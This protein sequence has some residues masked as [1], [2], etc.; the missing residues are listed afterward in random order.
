MIL[1]PYPRPAG[2]QAGF[3]ILEALIAAVLLVILSV[4]TVQGMI[5]H[6]RS[7]KA[8][9]TQSQFAEQ[10]RRLVDLISINALD[11]TSLEVENG[12][13]GNGSVLTIQKPSSANPAVLITN[14]FEYVDT[15]NN[16]N[17]IANNMILH[18][19]ADAPGQTG[20]VIARLVSRLP[21]NTPVFQVVPGTDRPLVHTRLRIG[22]RFA[23]AASPNTANYNA[24]N[25][26]TGRGY[27]SFVVDA[28]ISQE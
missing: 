16:A 17:T 28:H 27:Q 5:L 6:A 2:R 8:N 3:T 25:A 15:D 19:T 4:I 23:T 20:K 1:S 18:R 14:Q 22:D 9:I 21:G 12:G 26:Q 10:A 7:S 11:A 13:A 24:D